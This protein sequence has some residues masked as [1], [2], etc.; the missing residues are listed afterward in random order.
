MEKS[1]QRQRQ[2]PKT[3]RQKGLVADEIGKELDSGDVGGQDDPLSFR[4]ETEHISLQ[5]DQ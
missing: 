3:M 4:M 2:L 5:R 1:H